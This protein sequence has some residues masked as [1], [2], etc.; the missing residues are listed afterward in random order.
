MPSGKTHFH[1]NLL[2]LLL[3]VILFIKVL[4][5]SF[6]E[7]LVFGIVYIICASIFSP[8]M[9]RS[10]SKAFKKW[11]VLKVLW[12]PYAILSKHR[13][14]S[15]AIFVGTLIRILYTFLIFTVIGFTLYYL[16]YRF[17][18]PEAEFYQVLYNFKLILLKY[19]S[20]FNNFEVAALLKENER[21]FLFIVLGIFLPDFFHY[22][23]DRLF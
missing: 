7:I 10:N 2:M 23:L 19:N 21:F 5:F 6:I 17:N 22:L 14:I 18:T 1:I 13:G 11:G 15:H 4:S 12:Y 8:D 9:D 16:N 3:L 20:A